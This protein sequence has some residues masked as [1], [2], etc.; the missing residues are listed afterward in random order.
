[1]TWND[2]LG[3]CVLQFIF[4]VLLLCAAFFFRKNA[5]YCLKKKHSFSPN[6]EIRQCLYAK[7]SPNSDVV[8][9]PLVV[10]PVSCVKPPLY[11][12]PAPGHLFTQPKTEP[13]P[14][15]GDGWKF[16]SNVTVQPSAAPAASVAQDFRTVNLS[17]LHDN[18]FST[19]SSF[20]PAVPDQSDSGSRRDGTGANA[21]G[22]AVAPETQTPF[23]T[24]I[25]LID[26]HEIPEFPSFS[27]NQS[28][29]MEHINT[30]EFQALLGQSGLPGDGASAASVCHANAAGNMAVDNILGSNG[31]EQVAR[32]VGN[33]NWMMSFP[34]SIV[35]LL[36]NE[37][38][39]DTGLP[40]TSAPPLGLD[41]MDMLNSMDEDRLMSILNSSSQ[42]NF[43][44]GHST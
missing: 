37:Q 7:F 9:L 17:D 27:E 8:C 18:I 14:S 24:P 4:L 42:A 39:T 30:D 40:S 20:S 44:S 3:C 15:N 33:G 21:V 34:P 25:G 16:F 19:F 32:N 11:S 29:D 22:T 26:E 5:E 38:M 10:N 36:Q 12:T 2:T 41:E 28:S 23:A 35:N 1:M 6:F 13:A 31:A 43:L